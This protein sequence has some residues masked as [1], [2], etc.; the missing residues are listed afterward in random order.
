MGSFC[1][2]LSQ[3]VR[4]DL[5]LLKDKQA[6]THRQVSEMLCWLFPSFLR[7]LGWPIARGGRRFTVGAPVEAV[8]YE[9]MEN[10]CPWVRVEVFVHRT[11]LV[12]HI[13][14]AFSHSPLSFFPA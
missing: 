14:T 10:G 5:A 13:E 7:W 2:F 3:A 12:F 1:H 8:S 6:R 4:F 11:V 9:Y